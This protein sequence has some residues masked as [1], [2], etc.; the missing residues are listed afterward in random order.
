MNSQI[1]MKLVKETRAFNCLECGKCTGI[2]PVARYSQTFSPRLILIRSV[3]NTHP[4][5]LKGADLWSCLTCRQCEV[6]CPSDIDYSLLVKY[7][8]QGIG[9]DGFEG[10]CSHGGIL[11]SISRI[12]TTPN[13]RQNRLEWLTGE[14]QTSGS[15]D[16]LYFVGCLPYFEVMFEEIG[17]HLLNIA[18]SSLRILNYFGIKPQVLE[19]EKCCGH[20]FYW[21][22]DMENFRKLA[23]SNLEMIKKSGAKT[24][25]THCPE[26]YR[27]LK[28]DYPELFGKVDYQVVHIS[29]F[30]VQQ[31]K[32]KKFA[33]K[34]DGQRMTF[35]DPCRLGR[36]LGIYDAPRQVLSH[37][38]G[39]DFREMAHN[40]HRSVCC[41]VTGW[42]NC[43]QVSKQIQGFRLREARAAGADTLITACPKCQIHFTCALLDTQLKEEVNLQIKD[44]TEVFAESL[45]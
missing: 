14:Y 20:D 40:R 5:A 27:T 15:S 38:E 28:V 19:N 30:M 8:R 7:V 18:C 11:Q 29:E 17:I 10:T 37:L 31:L 25:V 24:I 12:M 4:D 32:D 44:L 39:A 41:G 43:S 35:Q 2:C 1:D 13:L 16:Y 26:C 9:H 36:H 21:N 42:V 33:L 45:Q 34:G 6:V 23:E 22:G 3:R